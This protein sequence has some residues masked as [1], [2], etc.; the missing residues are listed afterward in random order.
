LDH[1][2]AAFAGIVLLRGKLRPDKGAKDTSKD[3]TGEAN[4][5]RTAIAFF[6]KRGFAAENIPEWSGIEKMKTATQNGG[7]PGLIS[8]L[9]WSQ[10]KNSHQD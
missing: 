6:K 10:M 2:P 4:C 8:G 3:S 7:N 5:K 9:N 1:A